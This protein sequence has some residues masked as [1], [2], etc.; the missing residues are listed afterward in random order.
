[1]NH[2]SVFYPGW[3][4]SKKIG[5]GS[6]G[7]VFEIER[8]LFGATEKAAL[9]YISIPREDG[10]VDELFGS[11]YDEAS[12]SAHFD[13]CLA[14]I[15]REYALMAEM[16]GHPNIVYCDDVRYIR[17]T[18]GFGW[19]IYIKMELLT[20]LLKALPKTQDEAQ[21]IKLGRDICSALV[22]CKDKGIV[23][24]D[25]KP[26]N[27]FVSKSGE[28]KLGDFGI[29]KTIERTTGGTKLGTPSYMAPEVNNNQPYGTSADIYSLGMVMYWLLNERRLPFLP[30]PPVIPT[31]SDL[32]KAKCL[33]FSGEPLSEPVN[34]SS[35]IKQIILK[36]CAFET[37]KRYATA[38]DMLADLNSVYATPI[39][40]PAVPKAEIVAP[41][42]EPAREIPKTE[43]GVGVRI[44]TEEN[45]S[46]EK[47]HTGDIDQLS[48]DRRK[49]LPL[50]VGIAAALGVILLV[51]ANPGCNGPDHDPSTM[52]ETIQAS[53]HIPA[54]TS[55]A[56]PESS[57]S[58][59]ETAPCVPETTVPAPTVVT[60]VP[61]EVPTTQPE[62]DVVLT[63]IVIQTKP[64]KR[65]YLVGDKLNSDGLTLKV[66]YSDGTTR[67]I[68][69]GFSCSPA[70]LSSAGE[71]TI[72]VTYKDQT[73]T[74]TVSVE[75][76]WSDWVAELPSDVK[77]STHEIQE[78]KQYASSKITSWHTLGD[79]Q[80]GLSMY[81]FYDRT[82]YTTHDSG[83]SDWM[84]EGEEGF[85]GA[86]ISR[87]WCYSHEE[88]RE[89]A[90]QYRSRERESESSEYGEWGEWQLE[91]IPKAEN[92]QVESRTVYRLRTV[93]VYSTRYYYR[94]EDGLWKLPAWGDTPIQKDENTAVRTRTV[95]RYREK[96]D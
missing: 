9:K 1:M 81:D 72:R 40:P 51:L 5:N 58:F 18:D 76:T 27:I 60:T 22:L 65:I 88:M 61:S 71:Q 12:I 90:K 31:P 38:E 14:E 91:E 67:K 68:T 84:V 92:R 10:E 69:K 19:D 80:V 82:E 70:T 85:L 30:L 42:A 4:L 53:E 94:V 37:G 11:G 35:R 93:T 2:L 13:S 78:K 96:V 46:A 29:A 36:A 48:G 20:P 64:D 73:A 74:F 28:Y 44:D 75:N 63:G 17:H 56:I 15:V 34:G 26:Q 32:D 95:Y 41:V 83:W 49:L 39:I 23:H 50:I 54:T 16:K 62:K 87:P 43:S 21:V 52:M 47:E 8:D 79:G 33:R 3:K 86:I 25:I 66:S 6:F 24:R 57:E 7:T 45:C 77:A 55:A 59:C 89:D